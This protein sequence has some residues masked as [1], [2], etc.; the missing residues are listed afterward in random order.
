MEKPNFSQLSRDLYLSINE[1]LT[2]EQIMV[3]SMEHI[4]NT[5]VSPPSSPSTVTQWYSKE[6]MYHDLRRGN[7]SHEI[8]SEL[9]ER[10]A[11]DLQG[12]FE[13]G[14]EKASKAPSTVKEDHECEHFLVTD[15]AVHECECG[16]VIISGLGASGEY[17]PVQSPPLQVK[18][19]EEEEK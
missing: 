14:V 4:W 7:Y 6:E 3:R 10:W 5:Y 11:R 15:I 13:K 2:I 16:S 9:S 18:S 12:A 1:N 17:Y 19:R 8:A